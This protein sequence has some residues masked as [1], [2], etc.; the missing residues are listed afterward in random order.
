MWIVIPT[1]NKYEV[2][3]KNL[4]NS[5]PDELYP[6]TITI[7]QDSP[8][9]SWEKTSN[10]YKVYIRNN[11]YEYGAWVGANTLV[12]AREIS[13][14]DYFLMI[15]DTCEFGKN[16]MYRI[17]QL[18]NELKNTN[19]E[20]FSLLKGGFHNLCVVCK[21]GLTSIAEN[22]K[23]VI[24]MTK[25]E[26]VSFETTLRENIPSTEYMVVPIHNGPKKVYS[27]LERMV[28]YVHSLDMLKFYIIDSLNKNKNLDI[29]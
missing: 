8:N 18:E 14:D 23:E 17:I 1:L 16:T 12:Q 11:I 13:E 15:H 10:G 22:F 9:D 4:W 5:I 24:S 26:A 19:I 20:Y 21:R 25:S 28:V 3:Y 2:A 29:P 27:D 7:F 6:K